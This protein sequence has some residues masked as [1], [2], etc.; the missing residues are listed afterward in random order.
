M[1]K[2]S[3]KPMSLMRVWHRRVGVLSALFVVIL[4]VTGILLNHTASLGLDEKA[5]RSVTVLKWYGVNLPDRLGGIRLGNDWLVSLSGRVF[6]N[7]YYLGDCEGRLL[8]AGFF[9]EELAIICEEKVLLASKTGQLIEQLG[10]GNE[11]REISEQ[12]P[13]ANSAFEEVPGVLQESLLSFAAGNEITLERLL[14]DIHSGRILGPWGVLLM[15]FMATLFVILAL[16][17][18]FIWWR[19]T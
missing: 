17:G 5:L 6:F 14:L 13:A 10:K 3:L 9:R 15:D 4:S 12:L 16:S 11:Y 2:A 1:R 7:Q 19:G 18:I 8:A